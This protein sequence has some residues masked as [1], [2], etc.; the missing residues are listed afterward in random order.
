M[1]L[2]DLNEDCL[3]IIFKN[4]QLTDL[5]ALAETNEHLYR[6]TVIAFKQKFN[7]KQI[8]LYGPYTRNATNNAIIDTDSV[9][10]SNLPTIHKI[11]CYYGHV[12]SNLDIEYR[13]DSQVQALTKIINA[14][15]FDSLIEFHVS[16]GFYGF[17]KHLKKP[18]NRLEILSLSGTFDYVGNSA[19][20]F[21]ELFPSVRRL[22]FNDMQVFKNPNGINGFYS[23][24]EHVEFEICDDKDNGCFDEAIIKNFIKCNSQIRSLKLRFVTRKL[25]KFIAENLKNLENL[26]LSAY[27]SDNENVGEI[28]F[29]NL[30][31][32][33]MTFSAVSMPSNIHF[34][35]LKEFHT[36]AHPKRCSRWMEF[37]ENCDT[38]T[39]F[40]ATG[41]TLSNSEIDRL[42][43]AHLHV[44]ELTLLFGIGVND[45]T[46]VK[47]IE[48]CQQLTKVCFVKFLSS[49]PMV[50]DDIDATVKT[51]SDKFANGWFIH[52]S[53]YQIFLDKKAII[54]H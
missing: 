37:V 8:K 43:E 38:L 36:D 7:K 48:N 50:Q 39:K 46:L 2:L 6:L 28:H 22:S 42:A 18:F 24:L 20:N 27:R 49:T 3:L 17:F 9:I 53:K 26:K 54:A 52:S 12:I 25:L 1:K 31:N 11:L 35:K 19:H 41:R 29:D 47:F 44:N 21:S 23:E 51:L 30:L 5:I 14:I 45:D 33:G 40:S 4:L 34:K 10:L 15:A 16:G 32:F 13:P